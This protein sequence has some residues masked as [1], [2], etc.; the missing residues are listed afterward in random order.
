MDL[1]TELLI[2]KLKTYQKKILHF[3]KS[4]LS[5]S[6]L[7]WLF[8]AILIPPPIQSTLCMSFPYPPTL[9]VSPPREYTSAPFDTVMFFKNIISKFQK[10]INELDSWMSTDSQLE[11]LTTVK[12]LQSLLFGA[13][14][15]AIVSYNT[16]GMLS[17]CTVSM[18]QLKCFLTS[19][20]NHYARLIFVL[21]DGSHLFF[22][23]LYYFTSN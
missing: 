7:K 1:E 20:E 10:T 2:E 3:F 8:Q 12:E 15:S 19:C 22:H 6:T 5:L 18:R 17:Y 16:A 13:Q 21:G 11:T 23:F 4:N 9:T 14:I